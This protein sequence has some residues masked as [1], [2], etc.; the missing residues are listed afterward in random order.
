M[1]CALLDLKHQQAEED[2]AGNYKPASHVV[3]ALL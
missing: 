2:K 1:P 3:P